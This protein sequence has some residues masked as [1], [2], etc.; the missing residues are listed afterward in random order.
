MSTDA[1]R[2]PILKYPGAKWSI[3]SWIVSHFP[4]HTHYLEPYCGSAAVFFAKTPAKHEVLNDLDESI[5][6]LFMV[7]REQGEELARLIDFTPW[8]ES[9]YERYEKQ[10]HN[11]GDPLEDARRFLVRSWQAHGGTIAQVSG[12]KHNGLAGRVYPVRLWRKLPERLLA[13]V[14]RLKEA[15][16]R[17]RPA[18]ELIDLYNHS[19]C[20]IYA[21][22]PYLL[23]TRSRKYYR[24]EMS[25]EEHLTLLETLQRHRGPVVLSGYSHPLYE[26]RL[27]GWHRVTI[28]TIT[29]HGNTRLE[30][31]WINEKATCM[32]QQSLFD[33]ISE[34]PI[35]GREELAL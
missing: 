33:A 30:V 31:L 15:E 26:E 16:I 12:W 6:N 22:P 23:S 2:K 11:T 21:D 20:L 24:Y 4:A 28:P 18:L 27:T 7:L 29:E 9:E 10:Y 8:S 19:D 35:A 5:V 25:N 14:D 34:R 17:N 13:V 32:Q 1:T 3:A